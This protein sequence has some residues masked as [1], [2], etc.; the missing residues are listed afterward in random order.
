M[1][2]FEGGLVFKG[3]DG[4]PVTGRINQAD[5]DPTIDWLE[6]ITG[7]P[8]KDMKLGS[9]GI[10]SSSGDM[11]IAVDKDK[12]SKD[13]LVAKLTAWVQKT[14]PDDDPKNWIRKSGINVHFKTPIQGTDM[15][16]FVQTDFMFGEPEFMKFAMKGF[17][18][19]VKYKGKHRAILIS[20]IAKFHGYKFNSQTG[21]VDRITNK[22]ISK[23][24]DEIAKYLLGDNAKGTDLDSVDTIVAKIKGDPNYALMV[25]DAKEW[26]EKDG[27]EMPEGVQYEGRDWFRHTLDKLNEI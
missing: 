3:E 22:S 11:D 2:L 7:L 25:A 9:T 8:H 12:V 21:L 6:A 15:K 23:N 24:P 13:D 5:I 18:D 4:Q 1:L 17:G 20:S 16:G 27:L 19:D 10:K 14:H 26:F